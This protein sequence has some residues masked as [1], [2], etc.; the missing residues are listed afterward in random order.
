MDIFIH[1]D[2]NKDN[3]NISMDLKCKQL[4]ILTGKYHPQIT[5]A[6]TKSMNMNIWVVGT[7]N[8]LFIEIKFQK[9]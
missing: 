8:Q 7:S 9:K 4:K 1:L 3:S 2:D 5:P 6:L